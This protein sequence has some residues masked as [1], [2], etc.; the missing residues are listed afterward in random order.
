VYP[1]A[2]LPLFLAQ[3]IARLVGRD[4]KLQESQGLAAGLTG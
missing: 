4:K 1:T 2:F 3:K